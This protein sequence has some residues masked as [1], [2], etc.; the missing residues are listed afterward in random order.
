MES[1]KPGAHQERL[2]RFCGNWQG[3]VTVPP[4]PQAPDGMSAESRVRTTRE[5]GGWF[6][7]MD[8]QQTQPGG[9][10]YTARGVVGYDGENGQYTFYWFDS[11][12]WNPGA[13]ALG[14]WEG[15]CIA[16]EHVSSMGHSRMTFDFTG[17]HGYEFTMDASPDGRQ[18]TRLMNESFKPAG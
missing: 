7:L 14:N 4:N 9:K 2:D 10:V 17:G 13:P 5:L 3:S 8:Y 16:F 15:D 11:D 6:V 12:G 18:W 1:P